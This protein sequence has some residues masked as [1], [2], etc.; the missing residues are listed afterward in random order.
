MIGNMDEDM[1]IKGC[2]SGVDLLAKLNTYDKLVAENEKLKN[3]IRELKRD[4]ETQFIKLMCIESDYKKE[5]DKNE[6]HLEQI[7]N[8]ENK[9]DDYKRKIYELSD[10]VRELKKYNNGLK[11]TMTKLNEKV[12][13]LKAD[14]KDLR[15]KI[16][17]KVCEVIGNE[18]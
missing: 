6:A 10:T 11:Q 7:H 3:K 18:T 17:K 8:L 4:Y 9:C 1:Y 16:V 14:N 13:M 15:E 5:Q 2:I 12:N